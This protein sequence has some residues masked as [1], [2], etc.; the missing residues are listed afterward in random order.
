[1]EAK[2]GTIA[3]GLAA[4][5]RSEQVSAPFSSPVLNAWRGETGGAFGGDDSVV[6]SVAAESYVAISS[7]AGT[8]STAHCNLLKK[9]ANS[10]QASKQRPTRDTI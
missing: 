8:L 1:M 5:C 7:V 2:Q 10:C 4:S 3:A 6:V 9:G